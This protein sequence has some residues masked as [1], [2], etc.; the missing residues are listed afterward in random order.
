MNTFFNTKSM[1]MITMMSMKIMKNR[2]RN[3]DSQHDF[4]S[5]KT[6]TLYRLMFNFVSQNMSVNIKTFSTKIVWQ[7]LNVIIR[8]VNHY[9][10]DLLLFNFNFTKNA[11]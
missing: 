11:S 8:R 6:L 1:A 3:F 7:S 10:T 9:I 5:G 2:N 4:F